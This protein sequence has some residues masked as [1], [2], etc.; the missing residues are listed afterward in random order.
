M[1]IS[2]FYYINL[3]KRP[4]RNEHFLTQCEREGVPAEKIH[5][6]SAL[7]GE[8][9]NFTDQELK[10]FEKA[11]FLNH[12]FGKRIMGNQLSH[13]Y[14]MRDIVKNKYPV[15]IVSQDDA[16][17]RNGFMVELQNVIDNMPKNTEMLNI[18]QHKWASNAI[19]VPWDLTSQDDHINLAERRLNKYVCILKESINPCSLAYIITLKGAENMCRYFEQNG[20]QRATD[21]NFNDYTQAR[22][23]FYGSTPVLITGNHNL[24]S[25]IF[26]K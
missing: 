16:I 9:H 6:F 15:S 22:G 2:K 18:G 4:N 12:W 7:D 26:I 13:Y 10:M 24:P 8:T 5:R 17:L 14:I 19:F 23:I 25:D 11:D 20:F 21:R 1:E 3:D